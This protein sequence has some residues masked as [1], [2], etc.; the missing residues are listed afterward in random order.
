[1][2]DKTG[3]SASPWNGQGQW[4]PKDGMTLL[5]YF[6]AQALMGR[7]ANRPVDADNAEVIVENCYKIARAMIAERNKDESNT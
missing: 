6:A 1:M 7:M 4:L 3:G 2:E 5:D